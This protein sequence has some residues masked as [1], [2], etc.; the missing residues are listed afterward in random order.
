MEQYKPKH[1]K[2]S[3]E[4]P[5][6]YNK[7]IE[8]IDY[9]ESWEMNFNR[10]NIIKYVTRSPYKGKELEDLKKARFYLEREI[11]KLEAYENGTND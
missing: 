9:I 2:E 7:G 1:A 6:H 4:H 10:G 3:V 5:T 8:T 11:K